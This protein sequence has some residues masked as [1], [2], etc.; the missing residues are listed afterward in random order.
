ML[1]NFQNFM[2]DNMGYLFG[3]VLVCCFITLIVVH[4]LNK[5]LKVS[6]DKTRKEFKQACEDAK[7]A[8]NDLNE[9]CKEIIKKYSDK[10]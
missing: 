6:M 5:R 8:A 3:A 9:A 2:V 4:V 7:K 1:L 10:N